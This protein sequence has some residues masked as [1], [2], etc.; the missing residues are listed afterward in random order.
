MA[1]G[2]QAAGKAGKLT[3]QSKEV[4]R[5]NIFRIMEAKFLSAFKCFTYVEKTLRCW[6]GILG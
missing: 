2:W 5:G 4:N 1:R 3:T 6:I